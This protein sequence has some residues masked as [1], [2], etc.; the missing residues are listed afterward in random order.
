MMARTS[1]P[2]YETCRA[3][4]AW[5]PGIAPVNEGETYCYLTAGGTYG[6]FRIDK[7]ENRGSEI[8]QWI[9]GLSYTVWIP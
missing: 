4:G 8:A 1:S 2:S 3:V 7:I 6:Y 9:I 5:Y